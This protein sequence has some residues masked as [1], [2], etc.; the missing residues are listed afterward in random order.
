MPDYATAFS[1]RR[2][3]VI[4]MFGAVFSFQVG[5]GAGYHSG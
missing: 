2:G 1:I 3:E 5:L 4:L